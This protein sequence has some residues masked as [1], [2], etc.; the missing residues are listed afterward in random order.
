MQALDAHDPLVAKI[1]AVLEHR[2][3]LVAARTLL[4]HQV[5][6]QITKLPP[7]IRDQLEPTGKIESR[8][9]R[10]ATIDIPAST[11]PAGDYRIAWLLEFVD[12]D[13]AARREVRRLERLID[14]LLD[15]H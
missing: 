13:R 14:Q 10:L 3:A 15:Q 1:E 5:G 7:E 11:T 9:R 12:Q 2:Q 4:L 8:L 6:D